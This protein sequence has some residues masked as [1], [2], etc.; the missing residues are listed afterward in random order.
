MEEI[1]LLLGNPKNTLAEIARPLEE[2]VKLTT[3]AAYL[4]QNKP[5]YIHDLDRDKQAIEGSILTF[6]AD[7]TVEVVV[8]DTFANMAEFEDICRSDSGSLFDYRMIHNTITAV[9]IGDELYLC[10]IL[11]C[12][13]TV[14]EAKALQFP[15]KWETTIGSFSVRD[16]QPDFELKW[17]QHGTLSQLD[18]HKLEDFGNYL[19]LGDVDYILG[20]VSSITGDTE[21]TVYRRVSKEPT[22]IKVCQ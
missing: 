4:K 19:A 16:G 21:F 15:E 2:C 18:V 8:M 9:K 11:R 10:E 22:S 12:M 5:D 13:Q 6:T 1:L 14:E 7:K 17:L 3:L 20:D